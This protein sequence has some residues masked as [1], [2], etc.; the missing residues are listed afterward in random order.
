MLGY[1]IGWVADI[2]IG[3][4]GRIISKLTTQID[5]IY[6]VNAGFMRDLRA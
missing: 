1:R 5:R 3:I 2:D 6:S 4:K